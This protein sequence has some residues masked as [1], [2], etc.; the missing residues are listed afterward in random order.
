MP[1]LFLR[2]LVCTAPS[3]QGHIEAAGGIGSIYNWGQG[4]A[5]DYKRALAAYRICAE[6]G[7]AICQSQLGFML[8]NGRGIDSPDYEQALVWLE[9]A[10]AQDGHEARNSLGHLAIHGQGQT[11]SWRRARIHFQRAVDLG[12]AAA[13]QNVLNL[14]GL[15]QQVT[16]AHAG[17]HSGL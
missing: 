15:I 6:G 17:D 16:R 1:F 12:N 13:A 8:C 3:T 2:S 11:P 14:D 4:V 10:A 7:N 9:K 5:I